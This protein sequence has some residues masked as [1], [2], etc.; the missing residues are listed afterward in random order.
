[1]LKSCKSGDMYEIQLDAKET[2]VRL[3]VHLEMLRCH[4]KKLRL[5]QVCI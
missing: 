2:M 4:W 1:M 5:N 3:E